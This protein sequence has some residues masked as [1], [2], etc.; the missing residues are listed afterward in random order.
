MKII[1]NFQRFLLIIS[2]MAILFHFANVMLLS[3]EQNC[4]IE[5]FS[6]CWQTMMDFMHIKNKSWM[7]YWLD[8]QQ[9]A[10]VKKGAQKSILGNCKGLRAMTRSL[11]SSS[12]RLWSHRIGGIIPMWF[13]L[14]HCSTSLYPWLRFC[15]ETDVCWDLR[16]L[17][18][19]ILR[20]GPCREFIH[21]PWT[22]SFFYGFQWGKI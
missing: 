22:K 18:R 13:T 2:I 9:S 11:T 1:E 7:S 4:L 15:C 6:K 14:W 10:M 16:W 12:H 17:R 21:D 5:W 8:E 19:H 3:E 20:H